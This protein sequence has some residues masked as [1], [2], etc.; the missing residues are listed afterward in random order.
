MINNRAQLVA[1]GVDDVSRRLRDDACSIL[2]AALKAVDPEQAI[3][4]ALKL[5]GDVLVFE[6][7]SVDLTKTNRVLVI[8]GGK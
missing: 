4:N 1:N 2:E 7:G 8:G 3:Y 5:D 6:G